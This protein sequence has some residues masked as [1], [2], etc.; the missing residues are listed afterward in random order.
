MLLKHFP[1]VFIFGKSVLETKNAARR[2]SEEVF[3]VFRQTVPGSLSFGKGDP[4]D[5]CHITAEL[6]YPTAFS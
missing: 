1:E 3:N 5:P 2:R 4:L 6:Q